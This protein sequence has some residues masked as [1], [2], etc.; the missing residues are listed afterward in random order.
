MTIPREARRHETP[1]LMNSIG[2][3]LRDSRYS[4]APLRL[5]RSQVEPFALLLTRCEP[6][7][8]VYEEASEKSTD[9]AG[10]VSLSIRG[11]RQS[12]RIG[13]NESI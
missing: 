9:L 13:T 12:H 4:S 8:R 2:S 3:I 5:L 11:Q 7:D 6:I 10:T 1:R